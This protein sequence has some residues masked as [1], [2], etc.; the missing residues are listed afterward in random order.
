MWELL[1]E[2]CELKNTPMEMAGTEGLA[3][4]DIVYPKYVLGFSP[5]VLNHP[6][7]PSC[8]FYILSV[9]SDSQKVK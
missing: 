1:Q 4:W 7:C 5:E 9:D 8:S 6:A 2:A 3:K